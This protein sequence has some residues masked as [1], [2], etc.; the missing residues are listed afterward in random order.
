MKQS[1]HDEPSNWTKTKLGPKFTGTVEALGSKRLLR[2]N[3]AAE[4][5]GRRFRFE[6]RKNGK[7]EA[8]TGPFRVEYR[9]FNPFAVFNDQ[10]T[11]S[12][13]REN[14]NIRVSK[15]VAEKTYS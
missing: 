1:D 11:W 7:S 10:L 8:G 4:F 9:L 5:Q 12:K 14:T 6:L 3:T 2:F 13:V 15:E